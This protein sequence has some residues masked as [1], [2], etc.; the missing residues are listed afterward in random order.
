MLQIERC[1]FSKSSIVGLIILSLLAT[2]I[3]DLKKNHNTLFDQSQDAI[4]V[5][6]I[7]EF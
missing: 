1:K 2:I 7:L 5:G 4:L 3:V 6:K